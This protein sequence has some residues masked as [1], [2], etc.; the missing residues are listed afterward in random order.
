[1][2]SLGHAVLDPVRGFD[3]QARHL[4]LALDAGEP[5]RVARGLA[6]EAAFAATGGRP[7]A[8]RV[9]KL[10]ARAGELAARHNDQY[11]RA[12]TIACGGIAAWL[13]GRWREAHQRCAAAEAELRAHC[14]GASWE[15]TSVQLFDFRARVQL[16]DLDGL[17]A[18]LE[19]LL[20]DSRSRGDQLAPSQLLGGHTHLIAL[21]A[22]DPDRARRDSAE[23]V[24]RWSR[25]GYRVPSAFDLWAMTQ[26]D[27]YTGDP[28]AAWQRVQAGWREL[29]ASRLLRVELIRLY[30]VPTRGRAAVA[31]ARAGVDTEAATRTALQC[32]AALEAEP[33]GWARPWATLI[34]AGLAGIA[35]DSAERA[36]L[37][38]VA[39]DG[40][41]T[42][43]M[44][45]AAAATRLRRGEEL[46]GDAGL[47]IA[48][49]ATT[50]MRARAVKVPARFAAMI[51]P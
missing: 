37:L 7:T 24:A 41:A 43:D 49:A 18:R 9:E 27:L 47:S 32:A 6:S 33:A 10:L 1:M 20:A 4:L 40:F 36:R 21:A 25:G 23:W 28:A 14:V 17:D 11:G 16:G 45:L 22:D 29:E 34:R 31:A 12:W 42:H 38:A 19:Q 51:A 5:R 3:F 50:E 48:D 15:I 30:C 44:A 2:I 8:D 26:T 39:S 35:G 13:N 46:G